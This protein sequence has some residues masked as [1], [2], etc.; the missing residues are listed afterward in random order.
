METNVT[1]QPRR[2][3]PAGRVAPLQEER[4]YADI[5]VNKPWGYEYLMYQNEHI[6]V[7]HLHIERGERTSLHCHPRKKTGLILLNGSAEVSFFNDSIT[8]DAV[9]KLMIRAGLF[10]ST[11]A[12]SPGGIDLIEVET[13]RHKEDLVRFED[14]YGREARPYEGADAHAPM[15]RRCVQLAEPRDGPP[16]VH[17][18]NGRRLYVGRGAD[19]SALAP[20][21]GDALLMVMDGGLCSA[22]G[23]P[24][25]AAGD[26]VTRATFN[27]LSRSFSAPAGFAY[28]AIA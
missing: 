25:L 1:Q 12:R 13:P 16:V 3:G 21:P 18:L 14:S 10:H 2:G 9:S 26:V 8:L 24:V 11:R 23:D 6:G 7:W 27:K 17:E 22:R 15:Q 4:D 20:Y 19:D 5:V 28:M